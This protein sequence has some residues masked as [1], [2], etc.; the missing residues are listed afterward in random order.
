MKSDKDFL[1]GKTHFS[2]LIKTQLKITI[3]Y[4]YLRNKKIHNLKKYN[5][6]THEKL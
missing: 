2:I 5:I 1:F 4:F 6:Y 3:I